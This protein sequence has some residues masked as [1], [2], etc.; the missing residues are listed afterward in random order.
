MTQ[1]LERIH[2]TLES[3]GAVYVS[4]I[5]L[6]TFFFFLCAGHLSA[7]RR[8]LQK[9]FP[10]EVLLRRQAHSRNM[11]IVHKAVPHRGGASGGLLGG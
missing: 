2:S 1:S 6:L 4:K 11:G 5:K 10:Q 8:K 3:K 9:G 7:L